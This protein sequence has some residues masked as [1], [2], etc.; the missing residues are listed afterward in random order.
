MSN[1]SSRALRQEDLLAR[2]SS[3]IDEL[4]ERPCIKHEISG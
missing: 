2:Q 1:A 3:R 4:S